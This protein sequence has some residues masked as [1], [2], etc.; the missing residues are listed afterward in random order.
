MTNGSLLKVESTVE[1]SPWS[2]LQYFWPA[3]SRSWK[4]IFCFFLE[5]PFYT[6]FT[7]K[8]SALSL[9]LSLSLS[10][11]L[12]L[13]EITEKNKKDTRYCIT[14]QGPNTKPL[15]TMWAT[16]NNESTTTEPPPQSYRPI[17][18]VYGNVHFKF[19]W[20]FTW[21]WDP[22]SKFSANLFAGN[23]LSMQQSFFRSSQAIDL[24]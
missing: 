1:C 17:V 7:V 11:S 14:K 12:S 19:I 2:I 21:A 22:K 20:P 23:L 18:G 4:L 24:A 3:L 8:E 13:C 10:L 16:I 5:W 15:Q 6:G 9:P